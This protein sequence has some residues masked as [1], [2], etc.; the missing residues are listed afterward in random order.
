MIRKVTSSAENADLTT[1]N[2]TQGES[3]LFGAGLQTQLDQL[4]I[5]WAE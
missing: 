1:A 3:I 5:G 2:T 4:T